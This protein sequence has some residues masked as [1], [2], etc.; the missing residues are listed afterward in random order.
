MPRAS[1]AQREINHER[2]LNEASRL[3]RERGAQ[4]LSVPAAM[5]A[6]GLTP[7]GFYKHFTSKDDLVAR[8][9]G[10]A[11]AQR[12]VELLP[13]DGDDPAQTRASFVELY[14]STGHRDNPGVGCAGAAMAADAARVGSDHELRQAYVD[15]VRRMVDALTALEPDVDPAPRDRALAELATVVGAVVLARATAGDP[16][17][18][19]VLA[20]ARRRLLDVPPDA[21]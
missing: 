14:L 1:R 9:T 5:A 16:L 17:S 12:L 4:A 19:D 7:G 15:G 20:A 11:F 6:A 13:H 2:V 18:D 8:A 21:G 3:V 10:E